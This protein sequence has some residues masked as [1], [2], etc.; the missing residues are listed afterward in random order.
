MNTKTF[1]WPEKKIGLQ[2][3]LLDPENHRLKTEQITQL[4]NQKDIIK[5]LIKNDD[6]LSL[7]KQISKHGFIPVE[8]IVVLKKGKKYVVLEGNRRLAALKCLTHPELAEKSNLINSFKKLGQSFPIESIKQ[9]PVFLAPNREEALK[10]FIIPKH[11]EPSIKRWS[12]YNKSKLY[13]KMI[14]D[15][16]KTLEKVCSEYG[17]EKEALLKA[18]RTYQSYEIATK[19]PL[20]EE[21]MNE[22][23]DERKFPVTNL[24]RLMMSEETQ[25][26]LGIRFDKNGSLKGKVKRDEFIKG[27]SK[28]VSDIALKNETSRTLDK[29]E[30]RNRYIKSFGRNEKPDLSKSG[31]FSLSSFKRAIKKAGE[32]QKKQPKANKKS[33]NDYDFKIPP[34]SSI[35]LKVY[36]EIKSINFR[37]KSYTFA[38]VFR[39]FLNMCCV[40]YARAN[41]LFGKIDKKG[42]LPTLGECLNHFKD[43]DTFSDKGVKSSIGSFLNNQQAGKITTLEILNRLNHSNTESISGD[44]HERMLDTLEQF[45]RKLLR[46]INANG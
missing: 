9:I 27:Y 44:L 19:L 11:T 39:A 28:I 32:P 37:T 22:V 40:Q 15:Q 14:L 33:L 31:S 4:K 13:A 41:N 34:G 42:E 30:D 35:I 8:K 21:I 18:L 24:D 2:D 16:G 36:E 38:M 17:L 12:T 45:L 5:S 29:E 1:N 46:G 25:K 43:E 10:K 7:A 3:L 6:I 26:F 23:L 20:S